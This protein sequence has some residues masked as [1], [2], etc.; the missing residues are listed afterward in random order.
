M[1]RLCGRLDFYR[2]ETY[3][4]GKQID[5]GFTSAYRRS[6]LFFVVSYKFYI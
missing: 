6:M 1:A 2:L 5:W 3:Y 4:K